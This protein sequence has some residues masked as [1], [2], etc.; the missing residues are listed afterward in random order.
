MDGALPW[1][2]TSFPSV[3][4]IVS[5][6]E[7]VIVLG[8]MRDLSILEANVWGMLFYCAQ[9]EKEHAFS[10]QPFLLLLMEDGRLVHPSRAEMPGLH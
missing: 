1:R 7:S 5:Q 4:S 9:V 6:H 10:T 2:Q 3:S 8:P